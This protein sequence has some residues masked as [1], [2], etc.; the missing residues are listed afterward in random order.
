[1]PLHEQG[2]IGPAGPAGAAGATGPAGPIGPTGPAGG[3]GAVGATGPQGP[4]GSPAYVASGVVTL[5]GFGSRVVTGLTSITANAV[6]QLTREKTAGTGP[7]VANYTI[8]A[9]TGFTIASESGGDAA[10]VSWLLVS[11]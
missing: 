2:I 9:G 7:F 4:A 8:Q 10:R 5:D 6:I 3:S 1:M 11:N